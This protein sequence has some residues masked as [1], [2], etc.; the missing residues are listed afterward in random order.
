MTE[1]ELEM[2]RLRARIW[3]LE[4]ERGQWERYADHLARPS[5]LT[6]VQ[7]QAVADTPSGYAREVRAAL[8][9]IAKGD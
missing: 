2:G 3:R 9:R 8:E 1:A 4:Q 6:D 7:A 5:A